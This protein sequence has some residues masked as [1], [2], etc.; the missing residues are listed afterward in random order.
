VSDSFSAIGTVVSDQDTPTFEIVRIKLKAGQDV[1]PGTLIRIPVERVE[2]STLIG[3]VRSAYENNP[4]ERPEDINVRDTLGL[5]SNYPK[6]EDSTTIY[7]QVE[8]DLIEEIIGDEIRSPQTLPNSGADVFV[9]DEDEIV[10]TLGLVKDE[11]T[12]LHIGETT[13]GTTTDIIL[14]REAIQRH[15][16]ICGTTG[17]GKSYAMGVITEELVK[18]KV[19]VIF[20]D[21][22][23][24]Y[25]PMVE[26]LGGKVLVPGKDFNIRISSLTDRELI[27]LV[28][29][30]SELHK[31]II[32]S[33]FLELQDEL[34]AGTRT[35]FVLQDL[36][37]KIR[38]IGPT[39]TNRADSIDLA[40]RRAQFLERIEIFG[41]QWEVPRANWPL[42]MTPCLAIKCKH[43][44][45]TRLQTV[46]TAV[47]REL[48]D[49][50]LRRFI[51]PYVAVVDEA[52]LFVPEGEG[53]PCK[54][55]IGEGVRIGRH[56]GISL[57]LLTQSPVDIDKRAIRQCNTRLVFALEP[58]QLDAI[59]GVKA[60][61]SEEMLRALPKMPRGMCLLSGTYES[62]K[63]T[64]PVKIRLHHTKD[65]VGGAT[66]NIFEELESK[67]L[68]EIKAAKQ[69]KKQ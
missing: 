3:R 69:R 29:T 20:I 1:R 66:P 32:T 30:D 57:V 51:P 62:V 44:T 13:G 9:A 10:R 39:L 68:P 2:N 26:K 63:H 60:D 65:A 27:D 61:A 67:W 22:Q 40:Y 56:H 16:F 58:D 36:L 37:D 46:A 21:T 47:L 28:P 15:M 48:Q 14:K 52:H 50:R 24:E 4:N 7:R 12:G 33:S 53:S 17:S 35:K 8:A 41:E 45:S 64:I 6:E 54:Q 59:R 18:H 31:N 38:Q 19:P 49:L 5:A 55:I 25:S 34:K 43:L 42:L 11:A 23:D